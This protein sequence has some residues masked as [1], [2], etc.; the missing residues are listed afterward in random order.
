MNG[1]ELVSV[2]GLHLWREEEKLNR[3]VCWKQALISWAALTLCTTVTE[4]WQWRQTLVS[5]WRSESVKSEGLNERSSWFIVFEYN[6]QSLWSLDKA[7]K[8]VDDR[9]QLTVVHVPNFGSTI[10][11][12]VDSIPNLLFAIGVKN[13][14]A[15]KHIFRLQW[16]EKGS[17]R[18]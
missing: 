5:E 7:I 1:R 9:N 13:H 14:G 6:M 12:T 8:T 15:T 17:D 2:L 4:F 11:I 16:G 18:C 10:D 3:R